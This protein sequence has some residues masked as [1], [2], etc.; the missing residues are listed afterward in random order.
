MPAAASAAGNVSLLNWGL[1]R[2]RGMVRTSMSRV[3]AWASSS[4]IKSASVRVECPTVNTSK[5]DLFFVTIV[6]CACRQGGDS[7]SIACAARPGYRS[8]DAPGV[9]CARRNRKPRLQRHDNKDSRLRLLALRGARE[10]TLRDVARDCKGAQWLAALI[11]NDP[12]AQLD[13][14]FVSILVHR[15]GQRRTSFGFGLAGGECCMEAA[16]MRGPQ[17]FRNDQVEAPGL[18]LCLRKTEYRLRP[19]VPHTD[20]ASVVGDDD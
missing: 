2:E 7:A 14:Q 5:G 17:V 6:L 3:T 20:R 1:W 19:I 13:V 4:A 10:L 18:R 16:P 9:A 15:P 12:E 8:S 11:G